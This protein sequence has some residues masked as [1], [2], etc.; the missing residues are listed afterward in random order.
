MPL[1]ISKAAPNIVRLSGRWCQMKNPDNVAHIIAVYRNGEISAASPS[2]S[3]SII[4]KCAPAFRNPLRINQRDAASVRGFHPRGI[5]NSETVMIRTDAQNRTEMDV[6]VRERR[7]VIRSRGPLT[8]AAVFRN[9][10]NPRLTTSPMRSM[11]TAEQDGT[12]PL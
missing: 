12:K 6:S 8:N 9:R 2:R 4:R 3:A 5:V 1:T 7:R 10:A 11:V